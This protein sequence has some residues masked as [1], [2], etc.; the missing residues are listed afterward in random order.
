MNIRDTYLYLRLYDDGRVALS[1][2]LMSTKLMS[3]GLMS[4]VRVLVMLMCWTTAVGCA[5]LDP[6]ADAWVERAGDRTTVSCNKT[7]QSWH[8]VCKGTM[9]VGPQTHD[10]RHGSSTSSS[11]VDRSSARLEH[12]TPDNRKRGRRILQTKTRQSLI[13]N[14]ARA[15]QCH[16]AFRGRSPSRPIGRIARAR[17]F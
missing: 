7:S 9:W 8:L 16:H 3:G 4:Y 15:V 10:C 5:N 12:A 6:P 17:K 14:F 13:S 1:G 11:I 2:R